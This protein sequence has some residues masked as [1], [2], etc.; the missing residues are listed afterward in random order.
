MALIVKSRRARSSMRDTPNCTTAWRPSVTMSLRNVVTS[1]GRPSLS[2]TATVPCSRPTGTV[3]LNS[4]RTSSGGAAVVR[5]KS[6]FCNCSKASRIAPP[7]H[8]VSYPACSSRAAIRSTSGGTPSRS[9]N[10]TGP[11]GRRPRRSVSATQHTPA[12]DV[13][14]LPGDVP[15]QPRAKK[16]DRAGDIP[17]A[18]H[19]GERNRLLDLLSPAPPVPRVRLRR[20]L[21]IDPPRRH[22]VHGDVARRELN[23]ERLGERNDG[24][25]GGGV[26]GVEGFAPLARGRGHEHDA[27]TGRE[28]RDRGAADVEHGVEV[29]AP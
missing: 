15:C 21:G 20:H 10:V 24:S 14:N 8:H 19:T 6:W 23:G 22:R 18:R 9:G 3:R 27:A 26:I 2:S 17:G 25:L 5:S 16:H 13:E 4:R 12:V 1:W 7:T 29:A 11:R 28:H